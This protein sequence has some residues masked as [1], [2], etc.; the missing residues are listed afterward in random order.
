MRDILG[1]VTFPLLI[2]SYQPPEKYLHQSVSRPLFVREQR[3]RTLNRLFIQIIMTSLA[4]LN[5]SLLLLLLVLLLPPFLGR[6]FLGGFGDLTTT[7]SCSIKPVDH[8]LIDL[9]LRQ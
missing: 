9:F 6:T 4:I 2:A 5:R 7:I 3:H 1:R 8:H